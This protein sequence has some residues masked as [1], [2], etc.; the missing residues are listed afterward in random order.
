ASAN[1][2][3]TTPLQAACGGGD[4]AFVAKLNATGT[5]LVYATYLGGSGDDVGYGIAVDGA[6]NAYLMGWTQSTNFPT[7]NSLQAANGFGT[8]AFVARINLPAAASG[9]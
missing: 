4:D 2:P 5:A 8:N 1:C 6:G 7:Q 9:F 3:T